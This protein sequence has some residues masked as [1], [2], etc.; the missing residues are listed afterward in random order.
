M[1]EYKETNDQRFGRLM[2]TNCIDSNIEVEELANACRRLGISGPLEPLLRELNTKETTSYQS[3]VKES[4]RKSSQKK[5]RRER[6]SSR[7]REPVDDSLDESYDHLVGQ[8]SNKTPYG[9]E[10][11]GRDSGA[12]DLSPEPN[13]ILEN[14]IAETQLLDNDSSGGTSAMIQLASKVSSFSV[15]FND[16]L[17]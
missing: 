10:S 8:K 14:L 5:E 7:A 3:E 1:S 6:Q 9:Q 16:I 2:Q 12:R 13:R 17:R 11:W 4:P 15:Q